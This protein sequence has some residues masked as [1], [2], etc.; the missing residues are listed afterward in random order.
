MTRHQVW[1]ARERAR[2]LFIATQAR[3]RRVHREHG[4]T[5][6]VLRLTTL[7][8]AYAKEVSEISYKLLT[9]DRVEGRPVKLGNRLDPHGVFTG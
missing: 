1:K 6:E 2:F 7:A 9:L 3:A 8:N 4:R 5:L